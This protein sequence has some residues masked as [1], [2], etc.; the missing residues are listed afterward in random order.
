[1]SAF[2]F[3]LQPYNSSSNTSVKIIGQRKLLNKKGDNKKGGG[4]VGGGGGGK[5]QQRR[6]SKGQAGSSLGSSASGGFISVEI[7]GLVLG[8]VC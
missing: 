8:K 6:A 7:H 2:M 5:K 4:G 1:M 3:L